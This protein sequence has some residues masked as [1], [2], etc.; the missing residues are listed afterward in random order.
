MIE[1]EHYRECRKYHNVDP[2]F[3][4]DYHYWLRLLGHE[5]ASPEIGIG[6]ITRSNVRMVLDGYQKCVEPNFYR[7]HRESDP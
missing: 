2:F 7:P 3:Q 5:L 1:P 4:C 6:W